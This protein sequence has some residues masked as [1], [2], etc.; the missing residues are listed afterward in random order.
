VEAGELRYVVVP[1]NENAGRQAAA[2]SLAIV[3]TVFNPA[4]N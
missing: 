4:S 3:E 1:F 2:A